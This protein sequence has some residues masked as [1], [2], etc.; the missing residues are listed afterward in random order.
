VWASL[1][2]F[3]CSSLASGSFYVQKCLNIV[4]DV[5]SLYGPAATRLRTEKSTGSPSFEELPRTPHYR[6]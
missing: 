1:I 5:A 2:E 6:V 3:S 4:D